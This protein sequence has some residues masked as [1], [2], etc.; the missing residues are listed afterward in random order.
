MIFLSDIESNI[1]VAT[2][3]TYDSVRCTATFI[4]S[5]GGAPV[6][7]ID[8]Y[9]RIIDGWHV[10]LGAEELVRAFMLQNNLSVLSLTVAHHYYHSGS[11]ITSPV[12]SGLSVV[13]VGAKL[14][15]HVR[16]KADIFT[17]YYFLTHYKVGFAAVG[18][19]YTLNYYTGSSTTYFITYTKQ[20]GSTT[21]TSGTSSTGVSTLSVNSIK[22]A[23]KADV[24][25]GDRTFTVYFLEMDVPVQLRFRN[26]F[27]ALEYVTFP[28]STTKVPKTEFETAQIENVSTMY[29]IEQLLDLQIKSPVLP[30][31]MYNSLLNLCRS[32]KVEMYDPYTVAGNSTF[33]T[34]SEV[35]V[36]E[37][38]LEQS[39][40][41][42]TPISLEL[43][44]QY[45]DKRNN[46]AVTVN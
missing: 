38:K 4:S 35:L 32:R 16:L 41:P 17:S 9:S 11:E 12:T 33:S 30:S 6:Y 27:N 7:V 10:F 8:L 28:G 26:V 18:G 3:V 23:V 36:K 1:R 46:D 2:G 43:T 22:G 25:M 15:K 20:D 42:N 34:W 24:R 14:R 21:V 29:D 40:S 13:Y 19:S 44:L 39:D 37:Y 31:S 5:S 45:A